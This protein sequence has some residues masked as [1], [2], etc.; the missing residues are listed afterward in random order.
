MKIGVFSEL[1]IL[2]MTND[3]K[4]LTDEL[5]EKKATDILV[6][7]LGQPH[8]LL[9]DYV[10]IVSVSNTIHLRSLADHMQRFHKKNKADQ[11]HDVDE[12]VVSGASDSGW[13]ILDLNTIVLHLMTADTRLYYDFDDVFSSYDQYRYHA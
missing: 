10:I 9:M 6:V 7:D 8:H 13:I 3:I 2:K 4:L 1:K 5:S 11:L 12:M